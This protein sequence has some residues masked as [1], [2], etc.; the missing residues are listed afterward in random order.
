MSA[1]DSED[2]QQQQRQPSPGIQDAPNDSDGVRQADSL[3][4]TNQRITPTHGNAA[5]LFDEAPAD[6]STVTTTKIDTQDIESE[7][8]LVTTNTTAITTCTTSSNDKPNNNTDIAEAARLEHSQDFGE[9]S[10]IKATT[11]AA[12][13]APVATASILA[14]TSPTIMSNSVENSRNDNETTSI[15]N[16]KNNNNENNI[17]NKSAIH[18]V[19]ASSSTSSS[20]ASSPKSSSPPA[21][22]SK[23]TTAM[24]ISTNGS[25]DK[26]KQQHQLAAI[27][28]DNN[29]L[30]SISN[31]V[32]DVSINQIKQNNTMTTDAK[33]LANNNKSN[34]NSNDNFTNNQ[35]G[36][37][38]HYQQPA[39]VAGQSSTSSHHQYNSRSSMKYN[40]NPHLGGGS[41][42]DSQ[43][44]RSIVSP[45]A[46]NSFSHN[47]PSPATTASSSTTTATTTTTSSINPPSATT[48]TTNNLPVTQQNQNSNI[49]TR[50]HLNHQVSS[51]SPFT[52][53]VMQGYHHPSSTSSSSATR[54][55]HY[56]S[57]ADNFL[58]HYRLIKTIGKGNFAK[59]KLAKHIPTMK[60]VA[61][62]II[63]K[64]LLN[65][66]SLKKLFRE[67]TIMKMLNHPNIVKLYEVIDSQRILYLVMEYASGGEVFDYL[68]A[69]GRMREKEA[70]AKFR[71]IVSAVQYC[72]QK[73][74]IHRDLKAENLLL[75]S[76]MNIKIADFGFSNEFVPGQTLDTFCGSPPYAAPEL[77]KGLRYEGPEVD[78]WSLGV[79][80]YTLVSG[81]L[82]FDGNNLKELRER[83]L[84]GKYR[85]P[86]YMSTDCENLLKK[87]LVLNPHKRASLETIMKD[88]WMN[89]GYED[90]ELRPYIEPKPNFSD[91]TRFQ[92]LLRMGYPIEEI[93][94]S[95]RNRR[96]DEVMANYL[97]LEQSNNGNVYE[98]PDYRSSSSLSLR[99]RFS[100]PSN[101]VPLSITG[102]TNN[103]SPSGHQRVRVQRSA[104]AATRTGPVRIRPPHNST[105]TPSGTSSRG[106]EESKNDE[107]YVGRSSASQ[108]GAN[109]NVSSGGDVPRGLSN[110]NC[111]PTGQ[112]SV[113]KFQRS[114][115][116]VAKSGPTR[117]RP[118]LTSINSNPQNPSCNNNDESNPI[119]PSSP[120][121]SNDP[122]STRVTDLSI[123]R[124]SDASPSTAFNSSSVAAGNS[125]SGESKIPINSPSA[126]QTHDKI[127]GSSPI[128]KLGGMKIRP[129]VSSSSNANQSLSVNESSPKN[130]NDSLSSRLGDLSL[131]HNA[132]ALAS[133][134]INQAANN[135][136]ISLQDPKSPTSP[137][138]KLSSSS[139]TP[140]APMV[141]VDSPSR[142]IRSP[143]HIPSSRQS[144]RSSFSA[145]RNN[146]PLAFD[147]RPL[148]PSNQMA[149]A[150]NTANRSTFHGGQ[151]REVR[152]AMAYGGG[153]HA[154]MTTQDTNSMPQARQS[155]F[156]KLS[157][158]FSK[159]TMND[160][161]VKPRSLR[162]TWSM[163]TTSSRHP[164]EIM[165]EIRKVLDK[166]DCD[167]EQRDKF[168]LLCVHGDPNNDTLVQ[169]EI[170]VCKLPRL[171]LNGVRFKRISGTS[172]GFKEIA[173]TITN[174]LKL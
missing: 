125:N 6:T 73:Q 8:A 96:Y 103:G 36:D 28:E 29:N 163:K 112:S 71:Q 156:S 52:P 34:R 5:V 167:Y 157:S 57:S 40:Q 66:Q 44:N 93:E 143:S 45:T 7:T 133:L 22:V 108:R 48:N 37:K 116:T 123:R 151:T 144:A 83:V 14:A 23:K 16:I 4:K 148:I 92:Q 19:L 136:S 129:L 128:S 91:S 54:H 155:F 78:I 62:K 77:F 82:P 63:D 67:V 55:R 12:L 132:G 97:L 70:R 117:N 90:D 105:T 160:D 35:S 162:F 87:F 69:H 79:I 139:T 38:P 165:Q 76:E 11:T 39:N 17:I 101:E 64:S 84:R 61:I 59:V 26:S 161:Q 166:N 113:D 65:Q 72:H 124:S 31:D 33:L 164:N 98:Q 104:S 18:Q 134:A 130:V 171:S 81:T 60:E 42:A 102:T 95:L 121:I 56:S 46:K 115:S 110:N 137:N 9:T 154:P 174:D 85:V 24:T 80:L 51:G 122:V 2:K 32:S 152:L 49:S 170:E 58:G 158:K 146:L 20:S 68:V 47:K 138:K 21:S 126:N 27:D 13:A 86:F 149:L 107:F 114:A 109:N 75:D 43:F 159:R 153:G 147:T 120:R 94:D 172:I 74:I 106:N 100:R 145:A 50:Q 53:I 142:S 141:S 169:W 127:Q 150:R 118:I 10:S 140:H 168:L 119:S 30:R 15:N 131:G 173:S 88:K 3:N 99:D 135:D 41:H 1:A 89:V 111:K 25:L